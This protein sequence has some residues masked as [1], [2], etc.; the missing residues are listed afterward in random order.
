[1]T[2]QEHAE[3]IRKLANDLSD[4]LAEAA[5]AKLH[6]WIETNYV[7]RRGFNIT[8]IQKPELVILDNPLKFYITVKRIKEL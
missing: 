1:M 7:D 6:I 5:N 8:I 2:D 4:A 3:K